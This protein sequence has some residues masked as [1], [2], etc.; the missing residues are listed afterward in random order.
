MTPGSL[1]ADTRRSRV[2]GVLRDHKIRYLTHI[3]P[4][5][6][7][8]DIAASGGLYSGADREARTRTSSAGHNSAVYFYTC[9]SFLPAWAL[10]DN[11]EG[12]ELAMIVLDAQA[13]CASDRVRFL[14]CNSAS[15]QA[16]TV[17]EPGPVHGERELRR[18][19]DAPRAV[20][21]VLAMDPILLAAFEAVLYPDVQT[22]ETWHPAF[23]AAAHGIDL[24]VAVPGQVADGT[25]PFT[26]RFGARY[27]VTRRADPQPGRDQ[28]ARDC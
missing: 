7:I 16:G 23:Q 26:F 27:S 22:M 12:A 25:E 1:G 3:T 10:C 15:S 2:A 24:R 21:E 8:P 14:P 17:L 6:N 19:L 5:T 9:C 11:A 20:A 13:V 4:A 18:S 28:R